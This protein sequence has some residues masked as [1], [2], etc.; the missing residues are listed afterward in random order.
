MIAENETVCNSGKVIVLVACLKLVEYIFDKTSRSEEIRVR[1]QSENIPQTAA[2]TAMVH[3]LG[4][5]KREK[6]NKFTSKSGQR[7]KKV[8]DGQL[9]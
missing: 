4:L 1:Y 6:A 8:T 2:L 7:I 3:Y 9:G 5:I